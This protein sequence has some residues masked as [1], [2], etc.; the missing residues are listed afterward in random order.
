MLPENMFIAYS[1]ILKERFNL[2][3]LEISEDNFIRVIDYT[4]SQTVKVKLSV[5]LGID[6]NKVVLIMAFAFRLKNQI[7]PVFTEL[8]ENFFIWVKSYATQMNDPE[9]DQIRSN[10]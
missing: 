10:S 6:I 1:S 4:I 9:L 5:A 8:N 3:T 2:D 7:K